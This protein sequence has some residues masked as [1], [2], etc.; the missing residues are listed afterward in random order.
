MP[1]RI[2]A[3]ERSVLVTRSGIL[4]L[5][6]QFALLAG[7]AVL[8]VA[9]MLAERRRPEVALLRS[10]GA[11][12]G[13]LARMAAIEGL[14]IA[15]PAAVLAPFLALAIVTG[16]G[17]IG[18]LA[19]AGI[20]EPIVLTSDVVLASIAAAGI[21]LVALVAPAVASGASAGPIRGAF[22][23]PLART[24]PQRLGLD[25]ALV[26]VAAVAIWQ[27]RLYGAP[28]T[29]N[30]QGALGV[31]VLLVAAPAIGL[32]AG[33][34]IATRL[35][36]RIAEIAERIVERGPALVLPLGARQVARRPLRYTRAALL[37]MLAA[38]LGTFA[39][40]QAATW[41]RSQVDQAAYQAATDVRVVTSDYPTLPAWDVGGAYRDVPG[42]R[43]ATAVVRQ[44]L[45]VGQA[46]PSATLLAVDGPSAA[47]VVALP[48]GSEGDATRAALVSLADGRP[49]PLGVALPGRPSSIAVDLDA[50]LV[51]DPALLPPDM[52]ATT[53]A[54]YPGI[55][56]SFVVVDADGVVHRIDANAGVLG[57]IGQQIE[58]SLTTPIKAATGTSAA[59]ATAAAPLRLVA[60]EVAL[61]APY[62]TTNVTGTVD[63]RG[64]AVRGADGALTSAPFDPAAPGW[65]W[66]QAGGQFES[67]PSTYSAPAGLP[68]RIQVGSPDS[69]PVDGFGV[70][71][72][73]AF[74][75]LGIVQDAPA[76]FPAI[77]SDAFLAA[78][79]ARIGDVVAADTQGQAIALRVAAAVATFPSLDPSVPFVVVDGPTFQ[80]ARYGALD[81]VAAPSEWWI[82]VQ[83]G[84]GPAV[85]ATLGG[86]PYGAASVLERTALE[87]SLA[88][89]PVALGVIGALALGA[90]AALA[91]AAIGFVVSTGIS[92]SE[93]LGEFA[94]LRALGL[95]SRDLSTWLTLEQAFLLAFGLIAGTVLGALLAWLVLPF[96]T[97]TQTGAAAVPPPVVVIPW[98][99]ILP[100]AAFALLVLLI[101]VW[102]AVRQ[103]PGVRVSG[104]L[105]AWEG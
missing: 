4:L 24:L 62:G 9:G 10:R 14:M 31:D 48:S 33:A 16:L 39:A 84:Q 64:I 83:P 82:G 96:T 47:Q 49:A 87:R 76:P 42:V 88:A 57:G 26:A 101:S 50:V 1:A 25:L 45:T 36:P 81:Q 12:S 35:V 38:S 32:L 7:Y 104:V 18:P 56:V 103:L 21:Y 17:R 53:V 59:P 3:V 55:D 58:A 77:A 34:V 69:P 105:R 98:S 11:G 86:D 46:V 29:R 75:R 74:Y 92:A 80:A 100:F 79:G 27:L 30:S 6:L 102:L 90:L 71:G 61:E 85:A 72:P 68:G 67:R 93:R 43:T 20:V 70:G 65:H 91:F 51:A 15:V 60:V 13:H 54:A 2:D 8:L 5:T 94:L 40:A 44:D 99:V 28:L 22:G 89:D 97:L 41:S 63:I 37:L 95:S 73:T 52:T 78:T 23:R 66:S 19:T